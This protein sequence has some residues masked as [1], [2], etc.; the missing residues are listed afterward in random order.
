MKVLWFC[1]TPSL[2][3]SYLNDKPTGG[4][5]IKSLEKSIQS[6]VH[7]SVAFYYEREVEPFTLGQTTYYPVKRF[8]N[9]DVSKIGRRVFNTLEPKEDIEKFVEIIDRIKPDV[10]HVHGTEF[11]FG[12]IQKF[13]N[14]P[15]VVSIQGIITVYKYKYFSKIT[16]LDVLRKARIK[17]LLFF[18][19]AINTYFLFSKARNRELDIFKHT[20]NLIGRTAWDRRVSRVLAPQARYFHNDEILRDLFY[21]SEWQY[22]ASAQLTLMTI[23]GPDIYKGI[24]TIIFSAHLLDLHH[25]NFKWGVAGI[26][27][28]D[29]IVKIASKSTGKPLS[30][31]II[32]MGKL[33]EQSLVDALLKA[34]IYVATSHIENSPNSLCEAL[35][36]GMPCIATYAGGTGSLITD[37]HDGLLIQDGD[38]YSMTGAIIEL[39]ENKELAIAMGKKA[40]IRGLLRHNIE[41]ITRELLAIYEDVSAD[42][43]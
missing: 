14:I 15:T 33:D 19:T 43:Y 3:E 26:S 39:N 25:I 36:L 29:E 4:G 21:T 20:K 2:S 37:G 30:D 42:Q 16:F 32:F 27:K 1:F 28:T 9:G 34:N 7:L 5:W 13:T 23:N 6:K 40:R 35:L 22:Q 38:P 12:L 24:E 41:T 18:R 11:P 17:N 31:N 8:T 10:I